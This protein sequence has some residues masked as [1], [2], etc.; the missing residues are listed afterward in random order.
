M[1]VEILLQFPAQKI[2]TNSRLHAWKIN[3]RNCG[4]IYVNPKQPGVAEI[5]LLNYIHA[6]KN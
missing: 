1:A 2:A 6:F 3:Y 5:N 4:I